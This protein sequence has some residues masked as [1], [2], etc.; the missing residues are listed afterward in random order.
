[1]KALAE[2]SL[3]SGKLQI[4]NRQGC[5]QGDF[6]SAGVALQIGSKNNWGN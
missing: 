1:M 5:I 2:V 4:P 3:K 6:D